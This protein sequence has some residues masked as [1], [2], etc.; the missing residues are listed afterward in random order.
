MKRL[1]G[2]II[3]LAA[4]SFVAVLAVQLR[5]DLA[6]PPFIVVPFYGM[7]VPATGIGPCSPTGIGRAFSNWWRVITGG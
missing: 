4:W 7:A 1:I 2:I 5:D 3:V 6:K